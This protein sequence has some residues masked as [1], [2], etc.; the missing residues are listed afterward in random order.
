MKAKTIEE[1]KGMAKA[2]SLERKHKDESIFIIYCNRTE[3]FYIDTDG[4]IR[5]WEKS[6]G[7]YVNGIYNAEKSHD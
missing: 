7:Y 1:A 5:L 2:Q 4:L 6:N 3:H